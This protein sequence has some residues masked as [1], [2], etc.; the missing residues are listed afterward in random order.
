MAGRQAAEVGGADCGARAR[1]IGASDRRGRASGGRGRTRAPPP[2]HRKTGG[3]GLIM[4]T[5][6][7]FFLAG[8]GLWGRPTADDAGEKPENR[9]PSANSLRTY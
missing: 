2:A 6:S 1:A 4:M 9:S 8:V 5:P 3:G 7:D